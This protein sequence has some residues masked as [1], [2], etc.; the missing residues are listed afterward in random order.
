[1]VPAVT[2]ATSG[3]PPDESA[4]GITDGTIDD[5]AGAE[6]EQEAGT[7]GRADLRS[8]F[9]TGVDWTTA[10]LLQQLRNGNIN[11]NPR[12]QRREVWQPDRKSRFIESILLNIPV[13]QIV[14]AELPEQRG[15]YIVLDGKQRLLTLRQFCSDPAAHQEDAPFRELSLQ[16]LKLREDLNGK[17]Y[18][19]LRDEP[20]LADDRD[21]FDNSTVRTVI[22]RNWPNNSYL[23]LVF[24]RLNTDSVA[25]SPQELRQALQPGRFTDYVDERAVESAPLRDAL[26]QSGPDFRMRDT[27]VLLRAVAFALRPEAY[28]GNLK[29]F[30]DSTCDVYNSSWSEYAAQVATRVDRIEAAIALTLDIFGP[31]VAFS[32]YTNGLPERR[33][34][35]AIFDVLAHSLAQPDVAVAAANKG[36]AVVDA[37]QTLCTGDERF[38]RSVTTTTKSIPATAYRFSAWAATLSNAIEVPVAVP[39]DFQA[40]AAAA[41]N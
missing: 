16:G 35:R 4:S 8:A 41:T 28:A 15:R 1:M 27:E 34:N 22:V 37:L 25:L 40:K 23:F 18:M 10:T 13:P 6:T 14:L 33:F 20:G 2:E 26:N 24:L 32:R 31:R 36:S 29:H 39:D 12:F 7:I 38:V 19:D 3:A 9:V 30:L 11:L 21:A 5:Y 17:R